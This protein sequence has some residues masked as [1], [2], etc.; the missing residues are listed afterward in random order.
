[1]AALAGGCGP[2]ETRV[3]HGNRHQILHLAN[4]TE[5]SDLD[6]QTST[7]V[8]EDNIHRALVE[9]LVGQH[10]QSL[11]PVPGAAEHWEI[12][13]D[14]KI[15]TFF[16]Q[17][18]GK[19]SNGE[20]VTANDFVEAWKRALSPKLGNQYAYMF[21]YVTNAEAYNKGDLRDFSQ[22]GFKAIDTRTLQITLNHPTPYFFALLAHHSWFPV[23]VP[24]VAKFG[25]L[26]EPGNRWTRPGNFVGNGPFTLVEWKVNH[27]IRVRKNTNYWD[28]AK[29]RLNEIYYY[30]IESL[31]TEERAFR[32]G[33]VHKTNKL[34]LSKIDYYAK[35]HSPFLRTAPYLGTYFYMINVTRPPFTDK[36]VRQAL[37]MAIDREA[38]TK[39]VSRAGELPAF[40]FT[41]PDTIGY[42][43]RARIP[44]D[45]A[46]AKQ[47]LA[48]AGFPDGRGFPKPTILYNTLESHKTIAEA[49][50]QMWKQALNVEA[51]LENQEWKVY[52]NTKTQKNYDLARYGW[53]ADYVDPNA[54]LGMWISGSGNNDTG[55]SNA[56]YD[57]LIAAAGA[58]T[59]TAERF[60][61]FQK[62]EAL[63]L[64]E[65]PVIPIYFYTSVYLLQPSVKE[66]YLNLLD[67]QAYKDVYLDPGS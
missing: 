28:A 62:A 54:F 47:L 21:F 5:P 12:S 18:N 50:Q 27:V 25:K 36:R 66:W 38:I 6:P 11:L 55:W 3:E 51:V 57:R 58:T 24:T 31:D 7:G 37:A 53:I 63:L 40:H 13:P 42:T 44:H 49:I 23:H 30:P 15:Y 8:Q 32:A 64:D 22:V 60:E 2:R 19:W 45:V 34:P 67:Q 39:S 10:K 26:Y 59:V 16:L 29:V 52:L 46:K 65:M 17:P 9:G 41:P 35:Q 20:P 61:L 1:M 14:G 4:G 43:A 48:E 33:Q 56:E